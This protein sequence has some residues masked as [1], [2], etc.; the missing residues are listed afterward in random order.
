MGVS[1]GV[2]FHLGSCR[3]GSAVLGA[4]LTDDSVLCSC[5]LL[6]LGP[7]QCIVCTVPLTWKNKRE[8]VVEGYISL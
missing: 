6:R 1:M 7:M 5:W 4:S 8:T 2:S 3:H